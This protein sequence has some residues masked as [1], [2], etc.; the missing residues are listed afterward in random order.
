MS[1]AT[2]RDAPNRPRHRF[3][4]GNKGRPKGA[5]GKKTLARA[6]LRNFYLPPINSPADYAAARSAILRAWSEGK[7]PFEEVKQ[8]CEHLKEPRVSRSGKRDPLSAGTSPEVLAEIQRLQ[9]TVAQLNRIVTM[10]LRPDEVAQHDV[11]TLEWM[12][13]QD[14]NGPDGRP[15]WWQKHH[16]RSPFPAN[17]PPAGK[18]SRPL[19]WDAAHPTESYPDKWVQEDRR[20]AEMDAA[21]DRRVAP[22]APAGEAQNVPV[23]GNDNATGQP[24]E[25]LPLTTTIASAPGRPAG[26]IEDKLDAKATDTSAGH[27]HRPAGDPVP[28]NIGADA[29]KKTTA[30]SNEIDL[31]GWATGKVKYRFAQVREAIRTRHG[32]E[33]QSESWAF[34]ALR[35]A[36]VISPSEWE[37]RRLRPASH[38]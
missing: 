28:I 6:K 7:I 24:E 15:D 5:L 8:G 33:C 2:K 31:H 32:H 3:A 14:F 10:A 34:D 25:R 36:G 13:F 1:Q 17:W 37:L 38:A 11:R 16:H 26:P 29:A 35:E 21:E 23:P 12:Q 9:A 4:K 22:G 19:W 20:R 30:T 27:D 18:I